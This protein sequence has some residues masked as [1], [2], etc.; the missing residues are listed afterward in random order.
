MREY[1]KLHTSFWSS[2]TIRGLSDDARIMAVYLLSGPHTTMIGC[3]RLPDG[4]I[5]EDLQMN[6]ERVSKGFQELFLNGFATRCERSKWVTIHKFLDWN[7]IENP[8]QA[9]AALKLIEQI[10]DSL[11]SKSILAKL[12]ED[13]SSRRF[14]DPGKLGT[15]FWNRLATLSKPLPNPFETQKLGFRNQEQE[16][17]QLK[18]TINL[19]SITKGAK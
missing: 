7:E 9:K 3:F 16:Q 14:G 1:G 19:T 17:E 2:E 10:P 12:L 13:I 8:N 5:S 18:P 6:F 4:Y 11:P 15:H